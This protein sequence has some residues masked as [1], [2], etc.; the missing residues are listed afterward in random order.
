MPKSCLKSRTLRCTLIF[1]S[2]SKSLIFFDH[3]DANVKKGG[4]LDLSLDKA[5]CKAAAKVEAKQLE[6]SEQGVQYL[7]CSQNEFRLGQARTK[8]ILAKKHN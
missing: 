8:T 2:S 1:S 7:Y 3:F 5:P 6:A 4:T